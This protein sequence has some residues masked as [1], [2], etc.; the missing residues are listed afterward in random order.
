V[1]LFADEEAEDHEDGESHDLSRGDIRV[2]K[3]STK[4]DDERGHD[5]V[6]SGWREA[7]ARYLR[8]C[9]LLLD[10]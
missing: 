10:R 1:I 3:G 6:E 8:Q 5:D 9:V 2:L 7:P 4:R